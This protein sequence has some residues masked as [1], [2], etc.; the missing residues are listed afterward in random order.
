MRAGAENPER[1]KS[2]RQTVSHALTWVK[3][4]SAQFALDFMPRRFNSEVQ[5]SAIDG[6]AE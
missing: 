5:Q 2:N 6:M 4:V 1:V 3:V